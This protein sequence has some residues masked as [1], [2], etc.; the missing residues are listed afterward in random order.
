MNPQEARAAMD[1]RLER[2]D[3]ALRGAFARGEIDLVGAVKLALRIEDLRLSLLDLVYRENPPQVVEPV[4]RDADK[5]VAKLEAA[6]RTAEELNRLQRERDELLR[7]VDDVQRD[8]NVPLVQTVNHLIQAAGAIRWAQRDADK[9][10]AKLEAAQRKDELK[11]Q[12]KEHA[13]TARGLVKAVRQRD[14]LLQ[15]ARE[16]DLSGGA[17]G[18]TGLRIAVERIEREI[19]KP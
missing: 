18:L 8:P 3:D 16:L 1:E 13:E 7:A 10:V 19:A 15:A 6:Q 5:L 12:R 17:P 9:L 11:A 4:E 14:E 2:W